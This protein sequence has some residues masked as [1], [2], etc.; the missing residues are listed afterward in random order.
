M[1][2][3]LGTKVTARL[4]GLLEGINQAGGKHTDIGENVMVN[5]RVS[6]EAEAPCVVLMEGDET[7][8][9]ESAGLVQ[10]SISYT[11]SAYVNRLETVIGAYEAAPSAEWVIKGALIQDIREALEPQWCPL[12]GLGATLTYEGASREA[13]D[14]GGEL[15]GVELRYRV[16]FSTQH[17]DFSTKP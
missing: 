5:Q 1:S 16:L 3:Y 8:Q 15:C 2:I 6:N 4:K 17:G 13:H 9:E 14:A 11:V 10:T 12:S 7:G